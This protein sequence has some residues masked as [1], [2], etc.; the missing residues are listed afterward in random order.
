MTLSIRRARPGDAEA[1][2][3]VHL[4]SIRGLGGESYDPEQVEA[5]AH[6]RDPADY[7]IENPETTV[8]VAERGGSIV[9][10]GWLST[11]PGGDFEGPADGKITAIYV[12]PAVARQGIGTTLV[13]A[14]ET[15]ARELGLDSL[16]LWASLN[17]VPFYADHGFSTVREVEYEFDDEIEGRVLEMRKRLSD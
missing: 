12:H 5:W 13:Q 9:G 1:I 10:F 15:R 7:P 17:A 3:A 11:E 16:G 8:F 6:D 2:R 4:A 14:L